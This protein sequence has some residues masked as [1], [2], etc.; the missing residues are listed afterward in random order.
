MLQWIESRLVEKM[1]KL[2][3]DLLPD[4]FVVAEVWKAQQAF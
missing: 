2:L 4:V 3:L 1:I